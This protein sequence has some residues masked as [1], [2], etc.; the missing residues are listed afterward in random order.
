MDGNIGECYHYYDGKIVI[1]HILGYF[2]ASNTLSS[3]W[4]KLTRRSRETMIIILATTVITKASYTFG[5]DL[6]TVGVLIIK[7]SV[8]FIYSTVWV[9]ELAM[10]SLVAE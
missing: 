3:G 8:R 9:R 7:M 1:S 5:P 6:L 4:T 10:S 2:S